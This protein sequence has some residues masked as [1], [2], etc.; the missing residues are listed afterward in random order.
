MPLT[1]PRVWRRAAP[2]LLVVVIDGLRAASVTE[3]AMPVLAAVAD[4]GVSYASA[5]SLVPSL[6]RPAAA[7]LTTGY[8]PRTTGIVA[9]TVAWPGHGIID[10]GSVGA[11]RRALAGEPV[12]LG[13]PG[14]AERFARSGI[15]CAV[16]STGSAGCGFILDPVSAPG[17]AAAAAGG[18]V[19]DPAGP[20]P[21]VGRDPASTGRVAWAC[22]TA[23]ALARADAIDAALI[24]LHQPDDAQHAFGPEAPETA[25]V[26]RQVDKNIGL[27]LTELGAAGQAVNVIVTA[28]HGATSA[29]GR[30]DVAGDFQRALPQV[31]SLLTVC[32]NDGAVL[33]WSGRRQSVPALAEFAEWCLAQPWSG[34]VF[35]RPSLD[36]PGT[37]ST[38]LIGCDHERLG[39]DV[40]ITMRAES[41]T[42]RQAA[43]AWY[44]ADAGDAIKGTHGTISPADLHIPLI[45]HGP[46]F[47]RRLV[48]GSPATLTDIT[49]TM[50]HLAGLTSSADGRVLYEALAETE[51]QPLVSR[52][53]LVPG[54]QRRPDLLT[55]ATV[56]GHHYILAGQREAAS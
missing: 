45:M 34:P 52:Y 13:A 24:W 9:N 44:A 19:H 12:P 5:A 25:A 39:P 15:R 36:I 7:A 3:T 20:R 53:Y 8:L 10:T 6:T 56:A 27:L 16:I 18:R 50:L 49:A 46:A 23:I 33:A 40:L 22:D 30:V 1:T 55:C 35:A 2:L 4:A 42:A 32:N 47:R 48:A 11:L 41:A 17:R 54:R 29:L 43:A 28:D 51:G 38:R 31:A 37:F 21:A 26:L 14:I